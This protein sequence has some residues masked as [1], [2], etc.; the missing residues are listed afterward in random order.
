MSK[1]SALIVAHNEETNLSACLERLSFAD[2]IVVVLDRCTDASKEIALKFGAR[3]IEGGWEI[4]GARRMAGIEACSSPWILEVDADEWIETPLADEILSVVRSDQAD[5]HFTPIHNYVGMRWV[6]YGWMAALAPDLRGSL[7]RK[8][9]KSW[10]MQMVHPQV[11]FQG[12][13]GPDLVHGVRHNFVAD[14][15]GL[16]QRFN[17]NTSLR[18]EDIAHRGETGRTAT[19]ARKALSRFWKC[20]VARRGYREGGVGLVIA[21]LAALYPL[22]AYLKAQELAQSRSMP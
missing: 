22:V 12:Q 2:E 5:F 10:G 13:R 17:R 16:I 1:L 6:R 18:A 21:A 19:M 3:T 7:F 4:E 20:Y 9:F 11:S 14:V 8:G 15:S